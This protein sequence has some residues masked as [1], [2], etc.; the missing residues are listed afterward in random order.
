[1]GAQQFERD[2]KKLKPPAR[3]TFSAARGESAF[4][5]I[6][7]ERIC[8]LKNPI[9]LYSILHFHRADEESE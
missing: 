5:G 6:M 9:R 8:G 3:Y 2:S 7:T 4:Y 1:M